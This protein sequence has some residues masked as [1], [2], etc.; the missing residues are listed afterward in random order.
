MLTSSLSTSF[1]DHLSANKVLELFSKTA[2]FAANELYETQGSCLLSIIQAFLNRV[3]YAYTY[4]YNYTEAKYPIELTALRCIQDWAD[5][6]NGTVQHWKFAPISNQEEI[7]DATVLRID[8]HQIKYL[9]A[10]VSTKIPKEEISYPD[11]TELCCAVARLAGYE[12]IDAQCILDKE[13]NEKE[14]DRLSLCIVL[15]ALPSGVFNAKLDSD[16]MYTAT[17]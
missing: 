5:T 2:T 3:L 9:A 13:E 14:K 12:D 10:K 8:F 6:K 15:R 16:S 4:P 1:S 7:R 11:F 17:C